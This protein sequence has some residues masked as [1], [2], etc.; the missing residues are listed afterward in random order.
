MFLLAFRGLCFWRCVFNLASCRI[1]ALL[2]RLTMANGEKPYT[3]KSAAGFGQTEMGDARRIIT[4]LRGICLGALL[5]TSASQAVSPILSVYASEALGASL[6]EVAILA[7]AFSISSSVTRFP[8]SLVVS[9]GRGK[10]VLLA[11]YVALCPVFLAQALASDVVQLIVLRIIG[12]FFFAI[13]GPFSLALS[14]FVV[15][16]E[17]RDSAVATYTA[18][19]A[20]GLMMGPAIGTFSVAFFGT[21]S[22]FLT[23]SAL[24]VAGLLFAFGGTRGLKMERGGK[25]VTLSAVRDAITNMFFVMCFLAIFCF[26][27]QATVL[28]A[29]A[30]LYARQRFAMDD[31]LISA[32]FFAYSCVLTVMRLA[33]GDLC[34]RIRRRAIL[35]LGLLNSAVV[36]VALSLSPSWWSFFLLYTLLGF[37]HGI[38]TPSAALIV[39]GSI[40]PAALVTANSIYFNS[41]D[42]GAMIGPYAMTSVVEASGIA[43]ALAMSSALSLLGIGAIVAL[44]GTRWREIL[45]HPN[46]S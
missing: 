27:F 35:S 13:I 29:Y 12:G 17:R 24:A 25:A 1:E 40:E 23:A 37:S 7:S 2:T 19:I 3:L 32:M 45:S 4:P 22:T 36:M 33:M 5:V 26:A 9:R 30:P 21:R 42:L 34:K 16:S 44:S 38:V 39:A 41:W 14:T 20:I 6:I 28:S 15:P 10:A 18:Y 8:L 43:S 46:V 11:S 31:A